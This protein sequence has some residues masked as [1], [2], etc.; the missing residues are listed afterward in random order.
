[1]RN[2]LLS[3]TVIVCAA[4]M[5]AVAEAAMTSPSV[6]SAHG[7]LANDP[8]VS[9]GS[10]GHAA[11]AWSR[12]IS[13]YERH[14]LVRRRD[15]NGQWGPL[16][17]VSA[18][19]KDPWGQ[20]SDSEGADYPSVAVDAQGNTLVTWSTSIFYAPYTWPGAIVAAYA[21]VGKPFGPQRVIAI[22]HSG[23]GT[24]YPHTS[25]TP[26][27]EA[28][29]VW[30]SVD[31]R[32][33]SVVMKPG[34]EFLPDETVSEAV[35]GVSANRAD[36]STG[37][38]GTIVVSW[39]DRTEP[40]HGYTDRL[41]VAVRRPGKPFGPA[42]VLRSGPDNSLVA[43]SGVA[44]DGSALISMSDFSW[45]TRETRQ[46]IASL[47]AGATRFSEPRRVDGASAG[48]MPLAIAFDDAATGYLFGGGEIGIWAQPATTAGQL[49]TQTP[50]APQGTFGSEGR[51][52][53][54]WDFDATYDAG[55][56]LYVG[57]RGIETYGTYGAEET[58][59]SFYAY[60][61]TKP[62]GKPFAFTQLV[63]ENVLI[64]PVRIA[65]GQAGDAIGG[66]VTGWHGFGKL[67]LTETTPATLPSSPGD[68]P[69]PTTPAGDEP[70]GPVAGP[71]VGGQPDGGTPTN[72][73]PVDGTPTTGQPVDGPPVDDAPT[74]PKTNDLPEGRPDEPEQPSPSPSA[75]GPVSVPLA[76][77]TALPA[78][79]RWCRIPDVRRMTL[80]RAKRELA[81]AGCSVGKV[82]R[83]RAKRPGRVVRQNTPGA[84]RDPGFRVALVVAR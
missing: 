81:V 21:P 39:S 45:K 22:D 8:A 48:T 50:I 34:G 60:V 49:G 2:V 20:H 33:H 31:N 24:Y 3:V 73:Q 67:F 79:R 35:Q 37:R 64:T 7:E 56:S 69:S 54:Q 43:V 59:P 4:L 75:S 15:P 83:V 63:H 17:R 6:V 58:D 74:A 9:V 28:V 55:G 57:W 65:A 14:A 70:A 27:G 47:P 26:N 38:D 52:N 77:T 1:M 78:S 25:F 76:G 23:S 62:K 72:G 18:S 51:L 80:A 71:P 29:T 46:D 44:N 30:Q 32:V 10:G 36:V 12:R 19:M 68:V 82:K 5:P 53:N 42:Q 41:L 66:W 84:V 11:V 13:P 61:V 16:E 40:P